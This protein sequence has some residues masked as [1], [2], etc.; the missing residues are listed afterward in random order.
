MEHLTEPSNEMLWY[1]SHLA[2]I[3]EVGAGDGYWLEK[4][5][6]VGIDCVGFDVSPRSDLVFRGDH[7]TAFLNAQA[8]TMLAVWPP[9]GDV[10]Q[11]WITEWQ[12]PLVAMVADFHRIELGAAL[13]EF[14]VVFV[15]TPVKTP[16][17]GMIRMQVWRRL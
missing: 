3:C 15:S 2:P 13:D 8:N 14:E 6:A 12:G 1:L 11:D 9:D 16:R 4:M 17:K 10:I 5:R 7:K